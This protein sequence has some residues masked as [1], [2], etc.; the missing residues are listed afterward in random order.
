MLIRTKFWFSTKSFHPFCQSQSPTY[1]LFL[2]CSSAFIGHHFLVRD[3][4]IN[5]KFIYTLHLVF[6]CQR[7]FRIFLFLLPQSSVRLILRQSAIHFHCNNLSAPFICCSHTHAFLSLF[8]I[9]IK[10]IYTPFK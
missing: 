8:L 4:R 2:M 3:S 1:S 10:G 6:Q 9:L 5:I 7:A